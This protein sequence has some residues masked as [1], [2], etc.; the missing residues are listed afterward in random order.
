MFRD[1]ENVCIKIIDNEF[2]EIHVL[3]ELAAEAN[4]ILKEIQHNVWKSNITLSDTDSNIKIRLQNAKLYLMKLIKQ[5]QSE[6]KKKM[7]KAENF[8]GTWLELRL[9]LYLILVKIFKNL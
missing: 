9:Q 1:A 7:L 3:E 8:P 2:R 4:N 6:S 5:N